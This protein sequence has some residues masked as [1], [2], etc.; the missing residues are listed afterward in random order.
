MKLVWENDDY[1]IFSDGSYYYA[2]QRIDVINGKE[3]SDFF[4]C[5][6]SLCECLVYTED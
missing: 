1:L 6:P 3:L 2:Y 4:F 5:S